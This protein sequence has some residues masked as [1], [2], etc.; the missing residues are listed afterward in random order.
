VLDF[1]SKPAIAVSS[2]LAKVAVG[3]AVVKVIGEMSWQEELP[4]GLQTGI[5][6]KLFEKFLVLKV[7]QKN[8]LKYT[9]RLVARNF[10][11][12]IVSLGSLS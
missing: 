4:K 8:F 6:K 9:E 10:L 2:G 11:K 7:F 5:A 12:R 1:L 3:K